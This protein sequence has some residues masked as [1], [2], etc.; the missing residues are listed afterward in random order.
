M[1]DP[2]TM[3]VVMG[4]GTAMQVAQ[5]RQAVAAQKAARQIGKAETARSMTEIGKRQLQEQ[6]A[7]AQAQ[8]QIERDAMQA[9]SREQASMAMQAGAGASYAAVLDEISAQAASSTQTTKRNL[10][11]TLDVLQ[12]QKQGLAA[13]FAMQPGIQSP[14]LLA[15]ALQIGTAGAQGYATGKSFQE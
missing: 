12:G 8:E 14:G 1:C 9:L 5:N 15:E 4:A 3:A 6:A 10:A 7:Q 13:S 2:V 11:N